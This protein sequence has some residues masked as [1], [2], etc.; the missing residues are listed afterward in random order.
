MLEQAAEEPQMICNR[1]K[2]V[3][4]VISARAYE[5][6]T[7]QRR[8]SISKAL[9]RLRAIQ[10]EETVEIEVPERADREPPS[11]ED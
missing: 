11:F 4:V 2:P 8:S 3:A 9:A 10:Q 7:R 5:A 1:D 6:S